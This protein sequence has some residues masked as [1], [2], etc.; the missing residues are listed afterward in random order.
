MRGHPLKQP[1]AT[2]I[3]N[4]VTVGG[5]SVVWAGG[6]GLQQHEDLSPWRKLAGGIEA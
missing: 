3:V 4:C 2:Y 6:Q 5:S 1:Y